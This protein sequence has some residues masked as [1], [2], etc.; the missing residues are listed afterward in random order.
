MKSYSIQATTILGID[1]DELKKIL[2]IHFS[3]STQG[4]YFDV[5]KYKIDLFLE[6]PNQESFYDANFKNRY[7]EVITSE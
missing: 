7:H 4:T 6:V 2:T 1:Y 3:N 5:P